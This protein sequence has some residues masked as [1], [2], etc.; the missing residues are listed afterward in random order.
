MTATKI[1]NDTPTERSG[2]GNCGAVECYYSY[3]ENY[4]FYGECLECGVEDEWHDE[5]VYGCMGVPWGGML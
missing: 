4:A 3:R 2:C 1:S 5:D